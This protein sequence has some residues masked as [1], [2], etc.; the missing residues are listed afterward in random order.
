MIEDA[1]RRAFLDELI[2]AGIV[3]TPLSYNEITGV[4]RRLER[5]W[6]HGVALRLQE[7]E[8]LLNGD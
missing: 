5:R 6:L 3:T 7:E 8:M 4:M 1:A 2:F